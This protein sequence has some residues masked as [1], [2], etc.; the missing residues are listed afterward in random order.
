MR[1]EMQDGVLTLTFD[2]P[3]RLNAIT[4]R[5]LDE[6][7]RAIQQAADDDAVR[8]VVLAGEGRA[9]CSGADIGDDS[10]VSGDAGQTIDAAN[11]LV[12]TIVGSPKVVVARAR[13]V[14]AGVGVSIALAADLVLLDQDS[15]LLLAFTRIGLMPDGGATALV[16]ASI[17][18]ARALR[19]ALLAEKLP[20]TEALAAGLVTHVWPA[21]AYDV[22][23]ARVIDALRRGPAVAQARTKAAVNAATLHGLDGAFAREREGQV[24]LLGAPDFAEGTSAFRERRAA[25]FSDE[26]R[27]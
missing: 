9:F 21:A 26:I 27:R 2:R 5:D 6:T 3:E 15:Y 16:A 24:G 11:R 22:E 23:A 10:E 7:T 20:A 4:T 25:R 18:R 12:A 8:V 1:T 19:M 17:G 13:G 14:V